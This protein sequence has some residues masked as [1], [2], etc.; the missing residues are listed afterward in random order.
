LH[1]PAT[2]SGWLAYLETLHPKAIA[3]GLDRVRAVHA[4]LAAEIRCPVV[5][6]AGT[7]GKGSTCSM[8]ASILRC[9]GFRVGLY[10]SPHLV[11]YNERVRIDGN[12][13]TD[14]T[15]IAAFDA[16]EDARIATCGTDGAP[17]PLTYFEFGTL[18]ALWLFA[19]AN[20]DAL[21]LEVG[22]GGR[23]DAVNVVDPDVA[24]LT[25]VAIDHVDYLG[26]TREDIGREKAGIFRAGRPAVCADPA[27]PASVVA[28]AQVVGAPLLLIGR[29]Y[30]CVNEGRQWR[31]R[32]PRGERF[33]LPV[34]ALR[35]AYQ[36]A[37][38]ATVLAVLDLLHARLPVSA[39]A[40][41]DGLLAVTLRGRFQVLPGRPVTVLDVAH[42]P[43][44]ARALADALSDMG[45]FPETRAVF[46][47]LADKDVGGV[48]AAV[49]PRV[50]RW[51]VAT[52]PGP[53]GATGER[54][55]DALLAA[56][57]PPDAIRVHADVPDAIA[58]ARGAAAEADRIVVFGSFLTVAA[59][60]P[61]PAGGSVRRGPPP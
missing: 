34:P 30:A 35:G 47:M 55:R 56:G 2:L 41:R 5:T 51:H 3:L 37:N 50:D 6:V 7:N 21:V 24:V 52:L 46:G 60:L 20:L 4:R 31:F 15:L 10:T 27:P 25:S 1:R 58:A 59:A 44:A 22:L 12:D 33:G 19:R 14:A 16:V 42:N 13:A 11:A 43:H 40:V 17:V 28:A 36:L 26:P 45:Y 8:L 53:R 9:A 54:L 38:A 57:V 39:G 18:A 48:I 61:A 32:G 23:L 49:R 29:D